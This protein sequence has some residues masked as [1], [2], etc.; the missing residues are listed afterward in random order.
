MVITGDCSQEAPSGATESWKETKSQLYF[1]SQVTFKVLQTEMRDRK[2]EEIWN[3]KNHVPGKLC[4]VKL[5]Y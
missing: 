3:G 1:L 5:K 4:E 2:Y